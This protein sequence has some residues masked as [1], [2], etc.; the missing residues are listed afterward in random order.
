MKFFTS[1]GVGRVHGNQAEASAYNVD[2][3][4]PQVC[5]MR[6]EQN[7]G[8]REARLKR[9]IV[10]DLTEIGI[11]AKHRRRPLDDQLPFNDNKVDPNPY[12]GV[13]VVS[14]PM[15]EIIIPKVL[16][17][18]G[19]AL[20][21]LF[22][23]TLKWIGIPLHFLQPHLNMVQGLSGAMVKARGLIKHTVEAGKPNG[24]R[25]LMLSS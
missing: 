2:L 5:M 17:D 3:S 13:L 10:A 25:G 14:V 20:N 24:I 12:P 9:P 18:I 8:T 21:I 23:N 15:A 4:Q 16:V 6:E 1:Y 7:T 19:S 22:T 11:T